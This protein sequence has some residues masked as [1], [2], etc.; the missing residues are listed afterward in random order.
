[1]A[2]TCVCRWQAMLQWQ[3]KVRQVVW[4]RCPSQVPPWQPSV[5]EGVGVGGG[6]GVGCGA[7]NPGPLVGGGT[8]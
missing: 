3:G 7:A 6:G 2:G 4:V 8:V 5:G 1:V